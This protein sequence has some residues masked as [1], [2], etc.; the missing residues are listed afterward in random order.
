MDKLGTQWIDSCYA[1]RDGDGFLIFRQS[2]EHSTTSRVSRATF[3]RII[4]EGKRLLAECDA[5]SNVVDIRS[6]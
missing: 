5:E 4:E 3:R 1:E 2:G 6:G